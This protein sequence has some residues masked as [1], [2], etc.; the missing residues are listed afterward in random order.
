[1]SSEPEAG[2]LVLLFLLVIACRILASL[3]QQGDDEEALTGI[4]VS[5]AGSALAWEAEHGRWGS[6]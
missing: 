3:P 6:P 2:A 5:M 1:M 4:M